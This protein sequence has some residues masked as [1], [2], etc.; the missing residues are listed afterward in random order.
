MMMNIRKSNS[1]KEQANMMQ[2]AT[3]SDGG[4]SLSSDTGSTTS[5]STPDDDS[6][7]SSTCDSPAVCNNSKNGILTCSS[8]KHTKRKQSITSRCDAQTKH[9][10]IQNTNKH[11]IVGLK[12]FLPALVLLVAPFWAGCISKRMITIK[13]QPSTIESSPEAA[14]HGINSIITITSQAKLVHRIHAEAFVHPSML[15]HKTNPRHVAFF[16]QDDIA[17]FAFELDNGLYGSSWVCAVLEQVSK[18]RVVEELTLL[19]HEGISDESINE[20]SRAALLNLESI[21]GLQPQVWKLRVETYGNHDISMACDAENTKQPAMDVVFWI[22]PFLPLNLRWKHAL[23]GAT[24]NE[25]LR[26]TAYLNSAK[27]TKL[28]RFLST[29]KMNQQGG[30]LAAPLA[31]API[32]LGRHSHILVDLQV[33]FINAIGGDTHTHTDVDIEG[34]GPNFIENHIY[35]ESHFEGMEQDQAYALFCKDLSCREH[36]VAEPE[37]INWLMRTR[38]RRHHV[39]EDNMPHQ[40]SFPSFDAVSFARQAKPS[41]VW[42]SIYCSASDQYYK[43]KHHQDQC[44]FFNGFN[45]L[46]QN[47]GKAQLE[48]K[49]SSLGPAVGRGLF[50]KD[51]IPAGSFMLLGHMAHYVIFKPRVAAQVYVVNGYFFPDEDEEEDFCEEEARSGE[52]VEVE[53]A[54]EVDTANE[55]FGTSWLGKQKQYDIK[56]VFNYLEGYGFSHETFGIAGSTVDCGYVMFSNH[57]C[58]RTERLGDLPTFNSVVHDSGLYDVSEE[59]VDQSSGPPG[60]ALFDGFSMTNPDRTLFNPL[61][62]RR[63]ERE[64]SSIGIIQDIEAGQEVFCNYMTYGGRDPDDWAENAMQLRAQCR[65]DAIGI[66]V[67]VDTFTVE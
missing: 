33:D 58:N 67:Q 9:Y 53:G 7:S 30:I 22:E 43:H 61:M 1:K 54:V 6:S 16:L 26:M 55:S 13:Q 17:T 38:L 45:P 46:T 49:P 47:V 37:Y 14:L 24:P 51:N 34:D 65:G 42:E 28:A 31:A 4:G 19:L 18:Y 56:K 10:Q 8:A 64:A 39:V 15:T 12:H 66:V 62:D 59:D 20:S 35:E 25:Q 36:R 60:G 11:V 2:Q 5:P 23:D 63:F 29:C 41:K 48:V 52:E 44:Q 3:F 50:S 40:A 21:C 32:S 57:G 27:I